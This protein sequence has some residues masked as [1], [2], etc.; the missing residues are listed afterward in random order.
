MICPGGVHLTK[1]NNSEFANSLSHIL[2]SKKPSPPQVLPG[3]WPFFTTWSACQL[4][5][6]QVDDYTD[7]STQLLPTASMTSPSSTDDEDMDKIENLYNEVVAINVNNEGNT[8]SD[9]DASGV[10]DMLNAH[11]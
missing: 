1:K 2:K 6:T 3:D 7:S 4:I 5:S 10:R 9:D 11:H 8:A